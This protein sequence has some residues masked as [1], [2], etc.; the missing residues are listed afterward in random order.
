M[1]T[2]KVAALLLALTI[3][4]ASSAQRAGARQ[5]AAADA[6]VS[7][8]RLSRIDR[9]LQQH[10]DEN[11]IAG[12]VALVLRD[13]RPI[14]E[15]SFGWSDK[16]AGR[17]MTNDTMWTGPGRAFPAARDSFRRLPIMRAFSRWFEM[18]AR[19]APRASWRHEPWR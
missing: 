4:S 8:E 9:V 13:G 3:S 6:A 10:V 16:E 18:E 11:R 19:T 2:L 17:R 12:A 1:R 14:Y 7:A 5:N 15:K